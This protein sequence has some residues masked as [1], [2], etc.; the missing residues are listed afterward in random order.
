MDSKT[1][2]EISDTGPGISKRDQKRIFDPFYTTKEE[3]TGL[4]LYVAKQL[5]ENHAGKISVA[6]I[7]GKGTT[8]TLQF[9]TV[10]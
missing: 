6:S 3:G 2:I 4:G 10:D 9:R 5:V 8:F 1:T 7:P